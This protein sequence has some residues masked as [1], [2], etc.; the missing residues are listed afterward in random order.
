[1]DLMQGLEVRRTMLENEP[2]PKCGAFLRD[3]A[4]LLM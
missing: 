2:S 3:K 4:G 1:M